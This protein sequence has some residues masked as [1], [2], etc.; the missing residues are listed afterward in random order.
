CGVRSRARLEGWPRDVALRPSFETLA[1]QAPQDEGQSPSLTLRSHAQHGVSKDEATEP[2]NALSF[3]EAVFRSRQAEIFPQG[4]AFILRTED[5]A[6]LQFRHHLVD[7]DVEAGGQERE[8][9]IKTVAA[10]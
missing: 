3:K 4:L 1:S 8:H 6:L 5:P 2:E 10:V 9:D 7:E